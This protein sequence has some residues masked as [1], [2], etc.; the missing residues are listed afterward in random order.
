MTRFFT[1]G[2]TMKK[3]VRLALLTAIALI[4]SWLENLLLPSFYVPGVKLGLANSITLVALCLYSWREAAALSLA[5][6]ILAGFLFGG[7]FSL[8]YALAGAALSLL[9]MAFLKRFDVFSIFGVS[10]LGG[11]SH[12]LAQLLTAALIT[13]TPGLAAYFPVLAAAGVFTGLVNA[14]IAKIVLTRIRAV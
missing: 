1:E 14:M 11:F 2:E 13:R 10:A 4:V 6:V 12:N 8:S 5:R 3:F 7:I 9:A